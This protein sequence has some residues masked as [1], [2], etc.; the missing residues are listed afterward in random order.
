MEHSPLLADWREKVNKINVTPPEN[1]DDR[2]RHD[3]RWSAAADDGRSA[4]PSKGGES[5]ACRA[6]CLSF[7]NL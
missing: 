4:P 3:G 6:L 5:G 2:Q 1:L 7:G